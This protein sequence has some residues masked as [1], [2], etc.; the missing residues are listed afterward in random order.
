MVPPLFV[1][2]SRILPH[3]VSRNDPFIIPWHCNGCRRWQ[4]TVIFSPQLKDVFL[5]RLVCS[6]TPA[7]CSLRSSPKSTC[8]HQRLYIYLLLTADYTLLLPIKSIVF[9]IPCH[10]LP[11]S[12]IPLSFPVI[13]RSS[14]QIGPW[15]SFMVFYGWPCSVI[16]SRTRKL[17]VKLSKRQKAF[18]TMFLRL[19]GQLHGFKSVCWIF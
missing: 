4:L 16:L 2:P 7:G 1:K 9:S 10:S 5:F 3:R 14:P 11:F 17:T 13:L 8:S 19:I 6:L 15:S 12:V 18:G